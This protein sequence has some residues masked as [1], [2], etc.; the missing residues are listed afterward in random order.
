MKSI[1]LLL[2]L[3]ALQLSSTL[4]SQ[5][6]L[7][8]AVYSPH[9]GRQYQSVPDLGLQPLK[10]NLKSPKSKNNRA[11]VQYG[12]LLYAIR[13]NLTGADAA[14]DVSAFTFESQI[15]SKDGDLCRSAE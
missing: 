3:G 13:R 6:V 5:S 11:R 2:I 1:S 10:F 15:K 14:C 12:V 4:F 7:L 9:H 8:D